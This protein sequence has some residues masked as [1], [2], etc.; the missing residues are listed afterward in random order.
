MNLKNLL[1]FIASA[2]LT[3]VYSFPLNVCSPSTD[4]FEI[5]T[6]TF[7][8][9]IP[10]VGS[11]LTVKVS[12]VL[13]KAIVPGATLRVIL[14]YGIFTV[15]DETDDLCASTASTLPCPIMPGKLTD[16]TAV[17]PIPGNAPKVNAY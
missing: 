17:I 7:T 12:G 10:K 13:S 14:K 1:L 6:L 4:L 9:E 8:P 2:S 16:L 11:D 15:H 3:A 5:E